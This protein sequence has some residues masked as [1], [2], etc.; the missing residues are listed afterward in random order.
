MSEDQTDSINYYF[1]TLKTEEKAKQDEESL[2]WLQIGQYSRL[3]SHS[4]SK[5]LDMVGPCLPA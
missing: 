3:L 2:G 5:P 4:D 1:P